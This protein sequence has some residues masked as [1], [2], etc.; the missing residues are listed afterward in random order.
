MTEPMAA[1]GLT[2]AQLASRG[3]GATAREIAQQ[4]LLWP[5][6]VRLIAG[7]AALRAFLTPLLAAP[8]LRIVLS[9]AGS[10][11]FVGECLAPALARTGARRAD[12]V[13]TTDIV[14]SPESGLAPGTP[15]LMVHFARSGNSPESVATMDLAEQ[16]IETCS[17]LI[18]TCNAEGALYRSA[19]RL[20]H[21]HAVLLPQ[22]CNDQSFAMTS[23]FTG[24]LLAAGIALGALSVDDSRAARL[25]HLGTQAMTS[26]LPVITGLVRA[27]F[28]RVVYLGSGELKGL[29]REASLKMLE[30]TDGRVVSIADAPLGFRHGPKTILNGSTLVVVFL[31]NDP[32]TRRYDLDLLA[33][34]RRDGVAGRVIALANRAGVPEHPDT[35]ILDDGGTPETVASP[36]MD[37]LTDLALCLPYAVFAQALAML[38]SLSLGLSPDNPNVAGTVNRV[39]QGVSTYPRS[40]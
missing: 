19:G 20:R 39:V 33:E 12:A 31:S 25:A 23:S 28:D 34:L 35:L 24:M 30:L 40:R 11:S 3:A 15:T 27:Q 29:A 4:P 38:R 36:G 26:C 6:I 10:S 32:G 21:S 16:L 1:L 8:Q 37:A 22:A 14:A 2:A 7:D 18:V 9:G 13:P 5:Q 17:H